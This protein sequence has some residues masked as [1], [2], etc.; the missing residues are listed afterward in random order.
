MHDRDDVVVD[1]DVGSPREGEKGRQFCQEQQMPFAVS[2]SLAVSR[3]SCR[4]FLSERTA[5]ADV[6]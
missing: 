6:F 1:V 5:V 4:D 2:L 3:S